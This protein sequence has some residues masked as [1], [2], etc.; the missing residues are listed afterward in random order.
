MSLSDWANVAVIAGAIIVVY[1]V[2]QGSRRLE[3]EGRPYVLVDLDGY[4]SRLDLVV[5]NT[6]RAA[7]SDVRITISPELQGDRDS[8]L[9]EALRDL[10]GSGIPQLSPGR[11]L[12]YFVAIVHPDFL[13][14]PGQP[15]GYTAVAEHAR[16]TS[17]LRRRQ[18]TYRDVTLI[19]LAHRRHAY[20]NPPPIE[21]VVQRLRDVTKALG[22]IEHEV[23][24]LSR[25]NSL[26]G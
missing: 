11:Q 21:D 12:R 13:D 3:Q 15:L 18:R 19:D 20:L 9:R 22:G 10:A 14:R 23:R 24:N 26:E 4:G 1:Q 5:H 7:A 17:R 25:D 2:V 16:P 8:S 6:G